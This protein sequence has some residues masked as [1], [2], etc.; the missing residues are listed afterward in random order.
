MTIARPTTESSPPTSASRVPS[1]DSASPKIDLLSAGML[2]IGSPFMLQTRIVLSAPPVA[3][4]E[5]SAAIFTT[6]TAASCAA[7]VTTG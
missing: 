3:N 7:T 2:A 5:L 4:R 6:A 1:G